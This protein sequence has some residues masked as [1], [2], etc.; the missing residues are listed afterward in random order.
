MA[1]SRFGEPSTARSHS[2]LNAIISAS[3]WSRPRRCRTLC[4]SYKRLIGSARIALPRDAETSLTLIMFV[5]RPPRWCTRS[6]ACLT[7]SVAMSP[8]K[9]TSTTTSSASKSSWQRT[10]A[11]PH[12]AGLPVVVRSA[13]TANRPSWSNAE[14][15]MPTSSP[16][17]EQPTEGVR[18][19]AGENGQIRPSSRRSGYPR[20]CSSQHLAS[21]LQEG[22]ENANTD[23]GFGIHLENLG[24]TQTLLA[25]IMPERSLKC[26]SCPR[27]SRARQSDEHR[28]KIQRRADT[29]SSN[30]SIMGT[31]AL[32]TAVFIVGV[33]S[34]AT[35]QPGPVYLQFNGIDGQ[36]QVCDDVCNDPTFSISTTG[37]LT[38]EAWMR[39]AAD[40]WNLPDACTNSDLP[41]VQNSPHFPTTE[42]NKPDTPAPANRYVHWLGKGE[43]SGPNA[44]QEW[45]FRM[46]NCDQVQITSSGTEEHRGGRISFYVFNLSVPS[47]Q[48]EGVG[49]YYQP[50]FGVFQNEPLWQPNQW[51]HL[52]GL[53]DGERTYL[54]VDGLFKK[55]DRYAAGTD[56]IDPRDPTRKCE[57]HKFQNQPLIITPQQGTAPLRMGHRD[58][59]SFLEGDLSQVRVWNRALT[60]QEIADLHNLQ[61]VPT[62]GLVAEYRLD[63]G[64]GTDVHDTAGRGAP[65]GKILGGATWSAP[66]CGAAPPTR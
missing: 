17:Q 63:E 61:A 40:A 6:A 53:A 1:S 65:N 60:E 66:T 34:C 11:S 22:R 2:L 16:P 4:F 44:Q 10:T 14:A 38:V 18:P 13:S 59:A 31:A 28:R 64:C 56:T 32:W 26:L 21:V 42:D 48:N 36:V 39:A 55:C 7:T 51:I 15:T 52:V 9:L 35:A 19:N 58:R 47:G 12:C 24:E 37:Q 54:Y 33:G 23:A 43:G 49:S 20:C 25:R 3:N 5:S 8:P 50:G 46:Y 30:G 45:T 29:M 27:S 41:Y 57:T 62:D